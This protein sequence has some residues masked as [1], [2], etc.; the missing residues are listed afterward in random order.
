MPQEHSLN[1]FQIH[2]IVSLLVRT[3]MTFQEIAERMNCTADIVAAVNHKYDAR[4]YARFRRECSPQQNIWD[5][6]S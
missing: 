5:K 6:A 4:E 3:E 1:D 2:R